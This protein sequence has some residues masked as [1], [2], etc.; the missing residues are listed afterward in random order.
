MEAVVPGAGRR[1]ILLVEDDPS[2]RAVVGDLLRYEGYEVFEAADGG[3]AIAALR[4]RRPP[5][6][7]LGL[8]ILDMM[9]PVADG[10][11]VLDALAGWGSYV[12][13]LAVSA[14]RG[15]LRRAAGA[16]ADATLPKPYD[17]DLLLAVVER[18]C[19]A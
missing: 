18:N 7:S 14:D 19:G 11:Q 10:V 1:A 3:A 12:P 17:L 13:V 4:D 15:Q 6:D 2:I 9:L 5:P 16:G 8:V